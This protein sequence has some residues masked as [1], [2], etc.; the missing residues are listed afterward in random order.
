MVQIKQR[1]PCDIERHCASLW[2]HTYN[3]F[4]GATP[5]IFCGLCDAMLAERFL[6]R[7]QRPRSVCARSA[8]CGVHVDRYQPGLCRLS[9]RAG[10]VPNC[11]AARNVA[12]CSLSAKHRSRGLTLPTETSAI[13]CGCISASSV[14]VSG[15]STPAASMQGR[16]QVILFKRIFT[17]GWRMSVR[18]TAIW[19]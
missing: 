7:E 3:A 17:N 6:E 13:T 5:T 19:T 1:T 15:R 11:F 12:K 10:S 8:V 9:R 2:Q 14:R 18:I 4:M 16:W